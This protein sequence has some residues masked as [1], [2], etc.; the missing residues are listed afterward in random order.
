LV[1]PF[2][3]DR[4]A[5]V[6]VIALVSA[7][8]VVGYIYLLAPFANTSTLEFE[9]NVP[10]EP[11]LSC[12][13]FQGP[14]GCFTNLT[15]SGASVRGQCSADGTCQ[16]KVNG[17]SDVYISLDITFDGSGCMYPHSSGI[18]FQGTNGDEFC[19]TIGTTSLQFVIPDVPPGISVG[20]LSFS[21]Q[22]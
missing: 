16:A 20:A 15:I 17:G 6:I 8:L 2:I 7:G 5:A 3:S 11:F 1:R 12:P 19:G 21:P 13:T 10:S 14:Y 22:Q 18:S 9:V 4:V